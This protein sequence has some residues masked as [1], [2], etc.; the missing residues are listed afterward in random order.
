MNA[1]S[2]FPPPAP[3]TLALS[4]QGKFLW[5]GYGE[6]IRVL[7]WILKRVEGKEDIACETPI[8]WV[9]SEDAINTDGLEEVNF[10]EL[11]SVPKDFWVKEVGALLFLP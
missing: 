5:P 2:S 1:K 4:P 3:L 7:D 6:N 10:K 11:L 8:G 9:P